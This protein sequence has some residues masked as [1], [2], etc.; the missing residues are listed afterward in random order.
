MSKTWRAAAAKAANT[1]LKMNIKNAEK[2]YNNSQGRKHL[3]DILS[4]GVD[5]AIPGEKTG[6]MVSIRGKTLTVKDERFPLEGIGRI[7]FVGTGKGSY[8][9]ALELERILGDHITEGVLA[10]KKGE[11]RGLT[12]IRTVQA[13]HPIPD[14]GSVEVARQIAAILKKAGERDIV[15]AAITGGASAMTVLPPAGIS[16][17]DLQQVNRLL[18]QSGG[19]I[20][21]MN[22][23]RRH[24]CLLK[25]GKL[26][27]LAQ[28]AHVVTI[29][30]QTIDDSVM[31]WPDMSKADP[32]TFKDALDILRFY[33]LEAGTPPAVLDYL[34]AGM[35][36]PER[37]T[38]KTL[39][40]I[41][42]TMLYA[43]SPADACEAAAEKAKA[44]GYSSHILATR[45]EGDAS[46]LGVFLAG[47]ANEIMA[48]N[49]PF[50][51]P[52]VLISGGE[53]TVTIR[54]ESGRGGPNM[55]TVLGF[56]EYI[57][58][59]PEWVFGA[60]DTDGTDGPTRY[61]GALADT[62]VK[63]EVESAGFSIRTQLQAHASEEALAAADALIETGHTGTN[64]MNL[65]VL[66]IGKG[67][68]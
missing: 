10:V 43:G 63:R 60:M 16:L 4:A 36:H 64:V 68:G 33:G 24:L 3:L 19:T 61:A 11:T 25:G 42:R 18:L 32:T 54:G 39:D 41:R 47:I 66:L 2:L 17:A 31:P 49:R 48:E 27:Q 67:E 22:T 62:A 8:P 52:C 44:L 40:G 55:E 20:R 9:I 57:A 37:E 7:Y 29:S 58:E 59:S 21:E 30:L 14:G 46:Q 6:R 45:I 51:R 56:L 65:R 23:I 15:F 50:T 28:P 5:A 35:E 34:K 13:G 38:L 12:Y 1:E 26:L 53:T